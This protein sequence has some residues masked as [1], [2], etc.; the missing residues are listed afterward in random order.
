MLP[1]MIMQRGQEPRPAAAVGV[2]TL[3]KGHAIWKR[4]G[5]QV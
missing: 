1:M 3:T 4:G 5:V 2:P